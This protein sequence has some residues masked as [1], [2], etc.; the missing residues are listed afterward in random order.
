MGDLI[1]FKPKKLAIRPRAASDEQGTVVIFT[2]VRRER[3]E[4]LEIAPV[5]ARKTR[6]IRKVSESYPGKCKGKAGVGKQL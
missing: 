6:R 1:A 5:K 2:G 3:A 4:N